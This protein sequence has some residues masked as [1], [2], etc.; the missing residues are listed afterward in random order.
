MSPSPVGCVRWSQPERRER[1]G[2]HSEP[3]TDDD[4]VS[5]DALVVGQLD[6]GDA[7]AGTGDDAAHSSVDDVHPGGPKDAELGIVEV[8][9]VVEHHGELGGQL[10]EQP[11]GV[12]SHRVGDDL[13]D[14]PIADLVAVAERTV[15]DIAPPVFG[16]PVDVGELVHQPGGGKHPTSDDDVTADEFDAEAVVIG[17][18]H[19]SGATGEDLSAV[20]SDLLTANGAQLR[21]G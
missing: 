15:D 5:V 6:R 8:G 14:A 19:P 9:R 10:A 18:R 3:G 12:Q 17:A 16:E 2:A 7:A 4:R 21:R 20:A 11:G 1:F 13:H